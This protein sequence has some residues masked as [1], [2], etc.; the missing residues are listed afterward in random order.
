MEAPGI[1]PGSRGTS[2][3]ASTCV[4]RLQLKPIR[5]LLRVRSPELQQARFPGRYRPGFLANAAA[6]AK[7]VESSSLRHPRTRIGVRIATSRVKFAKRLTGYYAA[8]VNCGSA[9]KF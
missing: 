1:E 9:V 8:R 5:R 4:A 3:P 2:A 7:R 6:E